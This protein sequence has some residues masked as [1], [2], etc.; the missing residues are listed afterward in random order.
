MALYRPP[1]ARLGEREAQGSLPSPLA[2][3]I[4]AESGFLETELSLSR[5]GIQNESRLALSHLSAGELSFGE[6][7]GD[8][9]LVSVPVVSPS[10]GVVYQEI[11]QVN[12]GT[13]QRATLV[14]S[15]ADTTAAQTEASTQSI[16]ES[17]VYVDTTLQG[18]ATVEYQVP[19]A[20][21]TQTTTQSTSGTYIA[22]E[23]SQYVYEPPPTQEEAPPPPET[24]QY[25]YDP[26]SGATEPAYVAP[27]EPAPEPTYYDPYADIGAYYGYY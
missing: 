8:A 17:D 4:S 26:Y 5:K 24:G 21:E 15:S 1:T 16:S 13:T 11:T 9:F 7:A 14:T 23:L 3:N 22:P 6:Q 2:S 19:V 10:Y 20:T 12:I 18:T 25:V 27:T